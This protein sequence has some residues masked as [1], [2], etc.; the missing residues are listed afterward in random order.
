MR[1]TA[2]AIVASR[3][4][5]RISRSDFAWDDTKS[6]GS[7]EETS[8]I[9]R[10][11]REIRKVTSEPLRTVRSRHYQAI[12]DASELFLKLS[13]DDCELI[14]LDYMTHYRAKGFDVKLPVRRF[15]LI[16]FRDARQFA[17]FLPGVSSHVS[18]VYKR[19]DNWLVVFDSRNAPMREGV[20]PAGYMNLVNLAHEATHQLSFNTGLL[21]PRGDVPRSITEGLG[22]YSE[23]RR[24]GGRTEPGQ[25][26]SLRLDH[27][28]SL[29]QRKPWITVTDLLTDEKAAFGNTVDQVILAYA[30]S[31]LL[32]YH[33]MTEASRLPQ[34]QAYLKT[35][36]GRTDQSHRLEDAKEHFGDLARL[37]RE[38]LRQEIRLQRL[39]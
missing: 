26:N 24:L 2:G 30:Q 29:L 23:S 22:M 19:S 9:K 25:V 7:D 14:A 5:E 13:V 11:E 17:R 10:A 4:L 28:A 31:W 8:E 38:L 12:G 1:R 18:G 33:L 36:Y 27:M 6:S 34:F 16:V 20:R 35:I 15:S 37:D 32:V 21:N 3:V 39:H